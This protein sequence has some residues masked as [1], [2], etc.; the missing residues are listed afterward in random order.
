MPVFVTVFGNFICRTAA[1]DVLLCRA[2]NSFLVV[3]FFFGPGQRSG[4]VALPD[5][6]TKL[7]GITAENLL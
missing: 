7:L 6:W 4:F 1:V 3:P 2:E 5:Q